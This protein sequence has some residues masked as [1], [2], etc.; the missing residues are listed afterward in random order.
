[1]DR[2]C[3]R[4]EM[5]Q[6]RTVTANRDYCKIKRT[7]VRLAL[8]PK[9]LSAHRFLGRRPRSLFG[10][11]ETVQSITRIFPNDYSEL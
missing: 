8:W 10:I 11:R 9:L 4:E 2:Y 5:C 1:M 3:V 7:A 6:D